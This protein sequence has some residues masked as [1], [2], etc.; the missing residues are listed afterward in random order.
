MLKRLLL[1]S[2][3]LLAGTV[4]AEISPDYSMVL[5]TENFPPYN[6]AI[7][8]KNFAQEDNIDGIAVD[9]VREMYKRAGIKYS[10]TLRFPWERIYKLALEKPDYGVFVTARLPERENAFKWVGPIGPD[11][12]VLLARG[13]SP[14][15]LKSLDEAKKYR[16]GAYK[17]DAMAEYLAEHGFEPVLALR[18]QENAGKLQKGEIDLWASGDP[19]GRYLAKQVGVSGLKT[20]LRFN[21]DQLYLAL[22][23]ETPDEVVQKLQAA[24][25]KMRAEG[26]V[27]DVLNSYL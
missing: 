10:M 3:L 4:H 15:A 5:L 21:S 11:D 12:W 27:D 17:G 7:N 13:D 25:D 16:V 9:I 2:S 23:K 14:I 18:D 19:A 26:F 22:N 8:G 20:V 1:A 6:M 24:L